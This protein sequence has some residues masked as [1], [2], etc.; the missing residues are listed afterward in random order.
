TQIET[1]L[2][3][4][5]SRSRGAAEQE[6]SALRELAAQDGVDILQSWDVAYYGEKLKQARYA[7]SDEDLRPYF[8]AP[9]VIDGLF[10]VV[11]RLYGIRIHA[12]SAFSVWHKDVTVYEIHAN[13]GSLS[14]RFYLDLYARQGKRG[15][16]WMDGLQNRR[17]HGDAVQLPVAF[18]TCNF[19]PPIGAD[20]ALLSHG[21]VTT[22]FHEFGHAL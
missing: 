3:D 19:A 4:L 8:P 13:D 6:L 14:A 20:P 16:A 21:E 10:K 15:G 2:L 22:L 17:R 9:A 12:T 18:V 11:E 1:F 5:A 7:L